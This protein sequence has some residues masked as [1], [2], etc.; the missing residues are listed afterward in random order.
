MDFISLVLLINFH[1]QVLAFMDMPIGE[2][3]R[4][5]LPMLMK[6]GM[7]RLFEE[8]DAV[9]VAVPHEKKILAKILSRLLSEQ[10]FVWTD[11]E[12]RSFVELYT[13]TK[14]LIQAVTLSQL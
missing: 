5:T 11:F 13:V 7:I 1:F 10:Q 8:M 6:A 2:V 14:Y 12:V 3:F 9:E 4:H